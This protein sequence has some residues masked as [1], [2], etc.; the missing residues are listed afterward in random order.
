MVLC[1]HYLVSTR[2]ELLVA[3]QNA[4]GPHSARAQKSLAVTGKGEGPKTTPL[5]R[6]LFFFMKNAKLEHKRRLNCSG[7][8][9]SICEHGPR[10]LPQKQQGMDSPSLSEG[11]EIQRGPTLSEPSRRRVDGVFRPCN[12]GAKNDSTPSHEPCPRCNVLHRVDAPPQP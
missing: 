3:V 1:L 4:Q 10:K 7:V 6:L 11:P 8:S 12:F 2:E 5:G 9:R